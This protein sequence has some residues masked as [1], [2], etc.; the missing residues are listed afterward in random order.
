MLA[1]PEGP[2]P[3]L[4]P[5]GDII[6]AEKN[7]DI[8]VKLGLLALTGAAK[9]AVLAMQ[10]QVPPQFLCHA[11]FGINVAIDRFPLGTLPAAIPCRAVRDKRAV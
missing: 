5:V 2:M 6:Q 3:K 11:F 10:G 1:S 4:T 7:A 9:S 8:T